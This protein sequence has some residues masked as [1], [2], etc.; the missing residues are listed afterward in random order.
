MS[1]R[2][3]FY[4]IFMFNFLASCADIPIKNYE[5][6]NPK[7]DI[8][9]FLNGK[10][11]AYGI[12]EDRK[13]K[14]TRRFTVNMTG[15]WSGN[16]GVLEE[17]FTFDDGEESTRVWTIKFTDKHNF[18][19]TAGDVIGIASGSQYGNAMQ[20]KY[21]L[22]LVVDQ[23]TNKKYKVSLDDWMFLIDKDILVNKSKIKKF[24]I[25]FAKLTIFFQKIN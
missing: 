7:L 3:I 21:I 9:E 24:G 15:T 19:A 12:L 10:V 11:K 23:E 14:I 16:N 13:G 5:Q 1:L 18:T 8:R 25:T 2:T 22:D 6:N 17:F 4:I 20:M